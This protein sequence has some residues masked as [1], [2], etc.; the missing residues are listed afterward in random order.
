MV[1]AEPGPARVLDQTAQRLLLDPDRVG[2]RQSAVPEP[3]IEVET[4]VDQCGPPRWL[5]SRDQPVRG[6]PA[7][8]SMA[9]QAKGLRRPGRIGP[10]GRQVAGSKTKSTSSKN[11]R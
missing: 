1:A 11:S 4:Q 5:E 3:R 8:V 9:D 6:D 7:I 2:L 10:G